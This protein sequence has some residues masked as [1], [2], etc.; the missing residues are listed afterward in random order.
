MKTMLEKF[1]IY[2]DKCPYCGWDLNSGPMLSGPVTVYESHLVV[3]Q[4]R[5]SVE[6]RDLLKALLEKR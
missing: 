6:I 5:A 2:D 4:L 1:G 3:C